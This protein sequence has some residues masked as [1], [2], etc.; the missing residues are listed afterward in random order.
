MNPGL[1]IVVLMG[2]LVDE[3]KSSITAKGDTRCSFRLAVGTGIM[4]AN[5]RE[6]A[7]FFDIVA[8]RKVGETCAKYLSKG[9]KA[10]IYG[11]LKSRTY[12]GQDGVKRSK[13]EVEVKI[14][15]F[16]PDGMN[17][18]QGATPGAYQDA[19]YIPVNEELSFP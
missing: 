19:D 13:V 9:R 14:V 18:Q 3:P 4:D 6:I 10:V 7:D 11:E 15:R 1:N 17:K 8:W 5:G 2:N 12:T 16:M